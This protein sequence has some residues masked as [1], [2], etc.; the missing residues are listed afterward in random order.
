MKTLINLIIWFTTGLLTVCIVI[1]TPIVVG[2][3]MAQYF[4]IC[5]PIKASSPINYYSGNGFFGILI[6]I[7]LSILGYTIIEL[8]KTFGSK[9]DY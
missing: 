5:L 6:I 3:V 7:I 9:E 4:N 2:L 1:L 8:I